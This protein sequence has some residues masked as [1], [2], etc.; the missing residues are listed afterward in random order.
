MAAKDRAPVS[1]WFKH[2]CPMFA[3]FAFVED[4]DD[5]SNDAAADDAPT[6]AVDNDA[7]EHP[8][9]EA[10]PAA[11]APA[12]GVVT[13]KNSSFFESEPAAQLPVNDA[14]EPPPD[15]PNTH[16]RSQQHSQPPPCAPQRPFIGCSKPPRRPI[17]QCRPRSPS[18]TPPNECARELVLG[19]GARE[20]GEC[21]TSISVC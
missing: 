1:A 5:A 19:F 2:R 9:D 20:F 11:E 16:D 21:S 3:R 17:H 15:T 10:A 8:A 18:L 4:R 14:S 12:V 6:A 13:A 7:E